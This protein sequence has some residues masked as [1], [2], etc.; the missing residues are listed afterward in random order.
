[1]RFQNTQLKL[2][3]VFRPQSLILSS[4]MTTRTLM[5]TRRKWM[6]LRRLSMPSRSMTWISFNKR[7]RRTQ[8]KLRL[9]SLINLKLELHR[10]LLTCLRLTRLKILQS[11]LLSRLWRTQQLTLQLRLTLPRQLQLHLLHQLHLLKLQLQLHHLPHQP[12]W[13]TLKISPKR[14]HLETSHP[15]R[16]AS[17]R[18]NQ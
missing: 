4:M 6:R 8:H 3:V 5:K 1:M 11:Q 10:S 16:K 18:C 13:A 9:W 14:I 17:T 15:S 12:Q 7:L 2:T